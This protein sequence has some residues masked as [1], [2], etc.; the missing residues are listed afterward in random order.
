MT[1]AGTT[2]VVLS[3]RS[4]RTIKRTIAILFLSF[5][6]LAVARFL[7]SF[8]IPVEQL[9]R[10]NAGWVEEFRELDLSS[11]KRMAMT[12]LADLGLTADQVLAQGQVSR[13][14]VFE[15]SGQVSAT[16]STFDADSKA[17]FALVDAR[18]GQI[19]VQKAEGLSPRRSLAAAFSVSSKVFDETL[20]ALRK[21]GEVRASS[22]VKR[23]MTD[24]FRALFAKR[25][26]LT[27]Y[28]EAL[29]KL[30]QTQGRVEEFLKL[31]EKILS[32]Q[33]EIRTHSIQLGDLTKTESFC[34][35]LFGLTEKGNATA[36][37]FG[38]RAAD[39]VIWSVEKTFYAAL[40]LGLVLLITLSVG[41]LR[42]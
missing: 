41:W 22:T 13:L 19:K 26:A 3:V 5:V 8:S 11:Y 17:F 42:S 38:A 20:D 27:Q 28:Q 6:V 31:E 36:Y 35:I 39:A 10:A 18:G 25:E 21:I 34:N 7:Y 23:D 15:Q 14:Q 2:P 33:E 37:S 32:L 12:N 40:V 16:T 4:L 9:S 24:T 29:S 1:Q 30:R